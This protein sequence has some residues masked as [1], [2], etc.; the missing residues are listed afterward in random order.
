LA[1]CVGFFPWSVFLSPCCIDLVRRMRAST[2][3]SDGG[4]P[5]PAD[6]LLTVWCIVWVG[7]FSLASTKFPHYVIPAYPAL[8]LLTARFVDRWISETE[9]YGKWAR[10][11][12]WATVALT[13]AGIL[14]AVP[15]VANLHLP[16]EQLL[17]LAGLPLIPGAIL[18]A[19][20]TER[21]QITK[22]LA[23]LSAT[24]AVF[25]VGLFAVAAPHVDRHQNAATFAN[26]IHERCPARNA[27][28][29][30]YQ[31]FRPGFV[32][33]C[34]E[35]VEQFFDAPSATTYLRESP[36]RSFLVT[37]E[38]EYRQIAAELPPNF[39]IIERGPWFLKQGRTLVL[40]GDTTNGVALRSSNAERK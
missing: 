4:D 27:R 37:T 18:C 7:F 25:F 5:R 10:R 30:T 39:G 29:A 24:A 8:A 6:L 34:N 40:L 22:A 3:H 38:D 31:F 36:G 20:L 2:G 16:G 1:I 19:L 35:R 32:Y 23:C 13:G 12:A 11:G 21:Q 26:A 28:I 9:I 14:I 17:C 33:Y 15:F